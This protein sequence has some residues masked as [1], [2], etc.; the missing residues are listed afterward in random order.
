MIRPPILMYLGHMLAHPS[1][2]DHVWDMVTNQLQHNLSAYKTLPLN[3]FGK[4]SLINSVLI[5][6]WTYHGVF[7]GYTQRMAQWD[8]MLLQFLRE[9][10]GVEPRMNRHN[11]PT[12]L[13]DV[14]MGLRQA[15]LT[16]IT[17]WVTLGE[18]EVRQTG[19][20]DCQLSA[21]HYRYL[22]AAR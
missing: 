10:P 15:W 6:R 8:D 1:H 3:G 13:R 5:R 22:D 14:G 4:V 9:T 20:T 7:L 2:E 18:N 11:I 16:F 17:R 12:D 19:S 21:T